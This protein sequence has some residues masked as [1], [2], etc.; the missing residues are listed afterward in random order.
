MIGGTSGANASVANINSTVVTLRHTPGSARFAN[1][2]TVSFKHANGTSANASLS[3]STTSTG[4]PASVN[5]GKVWFY[6]DKTTSNTILHI[7]NTSG[8]FPINTWV[9]GQ[10]GGQYAKILE[11]QNLSAHVLQPKISTIQLSNTSVVLSGKFAK[12]TTAMD[13]SYNFVNNTEDTTFKSSPKYVMSNTNEAAAGGITNSVD[14]KLELTSKFKKHSPCI[15]LDRSSLTVVENLI[16]DDTTGETG[17]YGGSALARYITKTVALADGN[18]A[19][20]LVAYITAFKPSTGTISV[21]YRL[22]NA[23]DNDDINDHAWVQMSQDQVA[24]LYSDNEDEDDYKEFTYSVPTANL[25]G[26]SNEVQYINNSAV[27][28]TGFKFFAVKVVLTTSNPANPP[29]MKDFRAIAL[30]I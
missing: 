16:N 27:T 30:Q 19:E 18:D 28:F 6:D 11:V 22:L 13:A 20:D 21:Y 15:D 12:S 10:S 8:V 24:T 7:A 9:V 29:K 17:A 1:S 3:L 23:E 26:S 2:E 4:V 14:L 25:T 5:T